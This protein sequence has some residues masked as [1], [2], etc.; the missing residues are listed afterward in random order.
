MHDQAKLRYFITLRA[1][2][3]SLARISEKVE[4]ST[5][6]LWHWD[7]EHR[8]EIQFLKQVH[9]EQLHE[10]FCPTEEQ[11]LTRIDSCLKRIEAALAQ[12][13]FSSIST[14]SLIR[15]SLRLRD[16]LA[17]MRDPLPLPAP[18]S[19]TP[20]AQLPEFQNGTFPNKNADCSE[21]EPCKSTTCNDNS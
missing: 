14:V 6:T 9:L 12:R 4:V 11:H 20:D 8:A 1:N 2:G 15:L 3:W 19:N 7:R 21:N 16:R 17:K 18:A 10:A 5:S 13:D